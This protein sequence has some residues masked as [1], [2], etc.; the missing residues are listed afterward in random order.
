MILPPFYFIIGIIFFA[1]LGYYLGVVAFGDEPD[2]WIWATNDWLGVRPVPIYYVDEVECNNGLNIHVKGCYNPNTDVI[3]IKK[4]YGQQW[5][6]Q[7]CTIRD[8]EILHAWGYDHVS[9]KKFNCPNPN[10]ISNLWGK[11]EVDNIHH[12][13]PNY[14]WNG[15][16]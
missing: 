13:N 16:R 8:H 6:M 12:W 7:G 10:D 14:E 1:F 2:E 5:A 11:Y 9:M 3:Q 15:Y 4:G